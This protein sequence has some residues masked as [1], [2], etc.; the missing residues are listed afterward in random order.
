MGTKVEGYG[1]GGVGASGRGGRTEEELR[2]KLGVNS[3]IEAGLNM[4]A[5]VSGK[6]DGVAAT[7][8]IQLIPKKS[9]VRFGNAS[10]LPPRPRG[11]KDGAVTAC[12]E[13]VGFLLI[14]CRSEGVKDG[15]STFS[16]FFEL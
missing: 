6:V 13:N 11:V 14:G 4:G 7:N 3:R 5:S 16:A 15:D 10:T 2:S 8:Q 12:E 9:S 1:T